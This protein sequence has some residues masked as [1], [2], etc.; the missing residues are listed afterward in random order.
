MK[1][2]QYNKNIPCGKCNKSVTKEGHDAC[3]GT[4][5]GV[6]NACCGHG[7]KQEAYIQFLDGFAIRGKDAIKIIKIFKRS[8]KK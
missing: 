7:K 4:L 5:P 1:P 2:V 3:L 6:M 8:V